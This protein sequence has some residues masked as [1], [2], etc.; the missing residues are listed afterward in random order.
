MSL[1]LPARVARIG[2]AINTRTEKHGDEDVAALDIP[3]TFVAR[4]G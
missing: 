3:V 2:G 4:L 1:N